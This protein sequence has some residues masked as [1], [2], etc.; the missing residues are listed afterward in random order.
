M[1][2]GFHLVAA[3]TPPFQARHLAA[4]IIAPATPRTRVRNDH[5]ICYTVDD[6]VDWL[7]ERPVGRPRAETEL[8]NEP[9]DGL[10]D[11][12]SRIAKTN[13]LEACR[14]S[15]PTVSKLPNEAKYP[16]RMLDFHFLRS[17]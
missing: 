13:P 17:H 9:T 10:D 15:I 6:V 12:P 1:E 16:L 4:S 5:T 2:Q 8:L 7:G 3:V 14:A 11:E